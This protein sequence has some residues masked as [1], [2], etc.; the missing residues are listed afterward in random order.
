M[1]VS[2]E[3]FLLEGWSGSCEASACV[4]P[5]NLSSDQPPTM[6]SLQ[7][8][9]WEPRIPQNTGTIA[10]LCA[11]QKVDLHVVG[12]PVFRLDDRQVRRAGLDYWPFVRLFRHRSL[13]DLRRDQPDLRPLGHAEPREHSD[14]LPKVFLPARR[15]IAVETGGAQS[16]TQFHFQ[17]G[18][19]LVFG[20]EESG[21]PLPFLQNSVEGWVTIPMLETRVRSLNLAVSVAMVLGEALRQLTWS[22]PQTHFGETSPE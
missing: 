6:N 18:D 10:R 20:S 2:I 14:C 5:M 15:L 21:L 13:E 3:A 4:P 12:R 1:S 11:A 9:L 19:C 17:P 22:P 16:Y 7:V 8:A